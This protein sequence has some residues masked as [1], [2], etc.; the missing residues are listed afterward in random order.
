LWWYLVAPLNEELNGWAVS[1]FLL[2]DQ[3]P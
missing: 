2:P 1:N 3:N